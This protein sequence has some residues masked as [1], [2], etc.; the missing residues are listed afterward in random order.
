MDGQA[1]SA[2]GS[3]AQTHNGRP[4]KRAIRYPDKVGLSLPPGWGD[5]IEAAADD[6]APADWLRHLIRN[7]L[8]AARKP[9]GRR[10][11]S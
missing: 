4:G 11:G 9:E 10:A 1:T 2:A 8:E 3:R 6:S 5:R 7:A